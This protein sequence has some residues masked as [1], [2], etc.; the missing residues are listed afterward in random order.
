[1]G[2]Q[3]NF[4]EQPRPAAKRNSSRELGPSLAPFRKGGGRYFDELQAL[5]S[6]H[7]GARA[8]R[9]TVVPDYCRKIKSPVRWKAWPRPAA[10]EPNPQEQKR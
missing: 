8:A 3:M 6:L 1:M 5:V 10:A 7:S 2:R 9:S 4:A